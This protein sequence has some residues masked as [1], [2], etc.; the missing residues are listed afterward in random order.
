[1]KWSA[2]LLMGAACLLAGCSDKTAEPGVKSGKVGEWI[3]AGILSV[4]V[5]SAE[6][7]DFYNPMDRTGMTLGMP[8]FKITLLVRNDSGKN[9]A[10]GAVGCIFRDGDGRN[11]GQTVVLGSDSE[12]G[13]GKTRELSTDTDGYHLNPE[14]CTLTIR[15]CCEGFSG[16]F[17]FDVSK[18]LDPQRSASER[19]RRESLDSFDQ[20]LKKKAAAK[21]ATS[22]GQ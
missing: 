13:P 12:L 10:I 18:K 8:R 6:I 4:M 14:A 5:K 20:Q 21:A 19:A 16:E 2:L 22:F 11:L 7:E 9:L 15:P 1:M 17:A 3:N